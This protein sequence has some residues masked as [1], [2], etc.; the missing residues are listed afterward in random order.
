MGLHAGGVSAE[1]QMEAESIQRYRQQGVD[2]Y[3]YF[4]HD[5][6]G[7][8]VKNARTLYGRWSTVEGQAKGRLV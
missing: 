4:N 7:F 8:A 6:K 5:A 1:L 3:V 2:V